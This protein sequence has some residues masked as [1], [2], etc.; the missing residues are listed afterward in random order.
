MK[1]MAEPRVHTDPAILAGAPVIRG[2]RMTVELI[3]RTL[4]GGSTTAE[5]LEAY[6]H[7]DAADVCAALDYAADHLPGTAVA[8]E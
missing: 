1:P 7:L 3:V 5:L 2:T 8:A 6:P 4:A